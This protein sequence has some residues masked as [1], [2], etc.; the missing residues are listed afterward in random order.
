ME[1]WERPVRRLP[2]PEPGP[3]LPWTTVTPPGAGAPRLYLHHAMALELAELA[4]EASDRRVEALAL[5]VGDWGLDDAAEPF[6]V[7]VEAPSGTTDAGSSHVRFDREGLG[8]VARELD[9]HRGPGIV[10]GW[11]HTHLGLG[12]F[13][14][15]RDLR[16]QRGGFPHVHQVALVV[17]A[18]RG[19][20]AAFA[21]GPD[22]PGTLPVSVGTFESWSALKGQGS[23]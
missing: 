7:A 13:M 8:Q 2:R 16:T 23:E 9:A 15:E 22:G 19:E 1:E 10:V 21:N 18:M 3:P 14:S 11:F 17:D 20:V 5:L 6:A 4:R 12:T